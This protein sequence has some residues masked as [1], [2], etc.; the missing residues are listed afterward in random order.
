MKI[1]HLGQKLFNWKTWD[2]FLHFY[3]HKVVKL[4][5]WVRAQNAK[6]K[7][8]KDL[9]TDNVNYR[10]SFLNSSSLF[11]LDFIRYLYIRC[12]FVD[13]SIISLSLTLFLSLPVCNQFFIRSIL[14][15]NI[16]II[17]YY[18]YNITLSFI[19]L[20]VFF[21][22]LSFSSLSLSLSF[23]YVSLSV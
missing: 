1:W 19:H 2:I 20:Y 8:W 4:W 11:V 10:K 22:C 17:L 18:L 16:C 23:V 9:R 6:R 5:Y 15:Q 12:I 13:F 7:R 14:F 3:F 21:L